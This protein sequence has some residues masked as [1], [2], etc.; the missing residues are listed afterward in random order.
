L[1]S[2]SILRDYIT[3][4]KGNFQVPYHTLPVYL[5]AIF[6]LIMLFSDCVGGISWF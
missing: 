3:Y 1:F 4:A 2:M 5:S 6:L